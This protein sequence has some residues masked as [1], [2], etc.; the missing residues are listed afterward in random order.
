LLE[1]GELAKHELK[2]LQRRVVLAHFAAS[3][4]ARRPLNE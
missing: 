3:L 1:S 4:N 2:L